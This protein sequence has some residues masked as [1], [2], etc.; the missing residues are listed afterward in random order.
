MINP[1]QNVQ[2]A[3]QG[4]TSYQD[5]SAMDLGYWIR[6]LDTA[7]H[8]AGNGYYLQGECISGQ[9]TQ[10]GMHKQMS[11]GTVCIWK[12]IPTEKLKMSLSSGMAH[13]GFEV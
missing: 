9:E 2:T 6:L 12:V 13:S 10:Q 3:T 8:D 4:S 11:K 5:A 7:G 1:V